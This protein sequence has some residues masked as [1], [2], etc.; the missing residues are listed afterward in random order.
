M[1]DEKRIIGMHLAPYLRN[2]DVQWD[3]VNT[4]DLPMMDFDAADREQYSLRPGD[5][6]VCEGGEV[7]RTAIWR[8]D[9]DECFF[10]K[11]IHRLRPT[12]NHDDSR[13]FRYF[14]RMAVADGLFTQST[15]ST[16][17]HLPAEKLRVVRY[18]SPPLRVQIAIADYLDRETARLDALVAAKERMLRLLVRKRDAFIGRVVTKGVDPQV[19]LKDSGVPWIGSIPSHWA[20]GRVKHYFRTCSGGTPSTAMMDVYYTDASDGIPWVRTTDLQND[21]LG[22][23]EVR[24]TQRALE[25]T[26]CAVLPK[27]T[28]MVAMYGGDGT[29][30]KNGMLRIDAAINQAVCGL[31]PSQTHIPEYV[32][33]YIQFYRPHWM[34]SAES[35]R[36]DANISQELVR[37]APMPLPPLREQEEIVGALRSFLSR[38]DAVRAATERSIVLIK[39]RRAALI[40]TAVT[41]ALKIA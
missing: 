25:D 7:G 29:V 2:V 31:L 15:A 10:Q 1:L 16:I 26:A 27:G 12:T 39:E 6:L 20:I 24:I 33:R 30:G 34:I 13:F 22:D 5:L 17:Q 8:G 21:M 40:S 37:N 36:K 19:P 38:H 3:G 35:S 9:I 11:A 23:V 32:F 28:V 18:P 4:T 41:G 14:M